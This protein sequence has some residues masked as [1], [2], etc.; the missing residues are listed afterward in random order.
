MNINNV[1]VPTD[2]SEPS[3]MA[4]NYGVALARAFRAQLTL[5]HILEPAPPLEIT[6]AAGMEAFEEQRRE[7][8]SQRLGTMLSPED[9]DD[10][11]VQIVLKSGN[12]RE[13]IAAAVR[14]YGADIVV[15]GTHGR[16]RLGRFLLGST[17]NAL[18]RRLPVPVVTVCHATAT[19]TMKRILFATD[20]SDASRI[21]FT[22]AADMAKTLGAELTAIHVLGE[23]VSG[24]ELGIGL[25]T[26]ESAIEEAH[27]RLAEFVEEG[28]RRG[29]KVGTTVARGHAATQIVKAA[30]EGE[31]DLIVLAIERKGVIERV[32][33]GTTAE[34]LIRETST[35]VLS[36]PVEMRTNGKTHSDKKAL[37]VEQ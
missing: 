6:T 16:G 24:G 36:V 19:R 14:E 31:A 5:V 20:L 28:A 9:E 7:E 32:L 8:A 23:L 18:L 4:L 2:F 34:Q 37:T 3:N 15:M 26:P 29:I 33:L 10:L 17:T 27:R 21:G 12:A 25:Q 30:A 22:F 1:M 11:N 35:P 13:T